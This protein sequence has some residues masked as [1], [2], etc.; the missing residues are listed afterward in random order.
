MAYYVYTIVKYS[1]ST[2]IPNNRILPQI[3]NLV[4]PPLVHLN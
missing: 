1:T 4:A 2:R 3:L